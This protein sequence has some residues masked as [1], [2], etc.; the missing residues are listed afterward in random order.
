MPRAL[1]DRAIVLLF[2]PGPLAV[3]TTIQSTTPPA[4]V[5]LFDVTPRAAVFAFM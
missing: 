5:P 3:D 1:D 2:D 4:V